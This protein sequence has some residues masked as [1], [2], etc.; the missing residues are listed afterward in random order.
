[1]GSLREGEDRQ[2]MARVAAKDQQ[3]FTLLY[4]RYAPRLGRFLSKSL[5][6][7]TLVND[8]VNDTMFVL[9]HKAS[10]FDPER[11][12][13]STWLFGI[14]HHVG[15][16]ALA[17]SAK[18]SCMPLPIGE[19]GDHE[20]PESTHDPATMLLGWELGRELTAALQ[21]LSPE[22]RAVIE[23]TSVEG[24]SYPQIARIVGCPENTVK[25]RMFHARRRLAQLL[26]PLELEDARA[27]AS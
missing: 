8:A 21:Q 11:A 22:H 6:S 20:E 14:A 9:W 13:L 26:S 23:L 24:L 25:T 18:V 10:E 19:E 3:A 2:L 7:H 4:Q 16:K 12:R 5:K 1:M 27:Y 17:R 15:L